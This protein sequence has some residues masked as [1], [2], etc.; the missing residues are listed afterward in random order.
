MVWPRNSFL[1]Y[2]GKVT[3]RIG[4]PIDSTGMT[5]DAL[6]RQVEDWIEGEVA[7]LTQ[8][9]RALDADETVRA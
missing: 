4:K 3:V 5:S 8:R 7:K 1:K 6:M 9:K 2:P